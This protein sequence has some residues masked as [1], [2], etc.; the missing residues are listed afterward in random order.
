LKATLADGAGGQRVPFAWVVS[1][2]QALRAVGIRA[3]FV[4]TPLN[5]SMVRQHSGADVPVDVGSHEE[6]TPASQRHSPLIV[7]GARERK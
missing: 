1:I 4:L 6:G 3:V 5:F 7:P 2:E